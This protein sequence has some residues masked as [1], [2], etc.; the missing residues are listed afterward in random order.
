M[1]GCMNWERNS[2]QAFL[3]ILTTF[4][5]QQPLQPELGVFIGDCLFRGAGWEPDGQPNP[6]KLVY[7]PTTHPMTQ[8]GY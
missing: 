1:A 3:G 2:T 8:R 5:S 6:C 4:P 7:A